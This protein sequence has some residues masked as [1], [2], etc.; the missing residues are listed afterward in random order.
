MSVL[1]CQREV[2]QVRGCRQSRSQPSPGTALLFSA[3]NELLGGMDEEQGTAPDLGSALKV[4]AGAVAFNYWFHGVLCE[5][6]A[7]HCHP[8]M[9]L[10]FLILQTASKHQ[11]RPSVPSVQTPQ[12]LIQSH[13]KP[14]DG[15]TPCSIPPLKELVC[16]LY[17]SP[18]SYHGFWFLGSHP[19][20]WPSVTSS[21]GCK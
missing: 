3:G 19:W 14:P 5:T 10:T 2:S 16:L 4:A 8:T 11:P 1:G 21:A 13:I 12:P 7:P 15:C 9:G 17:H 18:V 6:P 20:L